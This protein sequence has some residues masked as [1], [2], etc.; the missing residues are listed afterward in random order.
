VAADLRLSLASRQS[1]AGHEFETPGGLTAHDA[2]RLLEYLRYCLGSWQR[3]ES[4]FQLTLLELARASRLSSELQPH[5]F[6]VAQRIR[7]RMDRDADDRA[8]PP[9]PDFERLSRAGARFDKLAP[10]ARRAVCLR[11]WDR[12]SIGEIAVT[13]GLTAS[14]VEQLL[15]AA[16]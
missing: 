10:E 6:E 15:F 12:L 9:D 11:E 16:R 1:A 4:A 7:L 2:R 5:V 3:A 14:Q 8:N 13:V